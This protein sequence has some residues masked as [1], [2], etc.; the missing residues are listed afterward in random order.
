MEILANVSCVSMKGRG[1]LICGPVE[2]GKSTLAMAMIDR[3]AI[4]VGDDGIVLRRA[5]GR[6]WA[7]PPPNIAG[8]LEIRGVGIVELP[9][10]SAPL[11]LAVTLGEDGP[12]LP[13]VD[14][15]KFDG[16][17]LPHL[18]ARSDAGRLDLRMEYAMDL[19]GLPGPDAFV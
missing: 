10:I 7:D 15:M 6:L 17:D 3:G 5:H 13:D 18:R 14:W 19:H 1:L 2:S 4:L 12:R 16:G 11:C 9:T 8:K